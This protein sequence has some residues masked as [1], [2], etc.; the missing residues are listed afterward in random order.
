MKV[1]VKN[2]S[3]YKASYTGVMKSKGDTGVAVSTQFTATFGVF[4]KESA[5]G[6]VTSTGFT[7]I[8]EEQ[9]QALLESSK[10]FAMAVK[11]GTM[12]M[13]KDPPPEALTDS[14]LLA[15]AEAEVLTLRKRVADLEA[16]LTTG[17]SVPVSPA[18]DDDKKDA[19]IKKLQDENK[20]LKKK[21]KIVES[22]EG[23]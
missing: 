9:Y 7:E 3:Q 10:L 17:G 15:K 13:H 19:K 14:R 11:N 5:T 20:D 16:Q 23:L 2:N 1:F 21:L 8:E 18:E 4:A 22:T 6:M 12:V